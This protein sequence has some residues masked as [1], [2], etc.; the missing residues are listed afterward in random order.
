MAIFTRCSSSSIPWCINCIRCPLI[1]NRL[2]IIIVLFLL[3]LL[4]NQLGHI[5]CCTLIGTLILSLILL[6]GICIHRNLILLHSKPYDVNGYLSWNLTILLGL[7]LLR[8]EVRL[9]VLAIEVRASVIQMTDLALLTWEINL[10]IVLRGKLWLPLDNE[11]LVLVVGVDWV[12]CSSV[13]FALR[14]IWWVM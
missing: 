12:A 9:W 11:A 7:I 6:G 13:V 4:W 14:W 2:L 3:L 1:L 5:G 8:N 10:V